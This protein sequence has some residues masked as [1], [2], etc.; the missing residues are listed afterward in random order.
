MIDALKHEPT[1]VS[2]GEY[3]LFLEGNFLKILMSRALKEL[4]EMIRDSF[5]L[6]F[7]KGITMFLLHSFDILLSGT[8]SNRIVSQ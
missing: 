5:K 6:F 1:Y 8:Q 7:Y 4:T 3:I 2:T